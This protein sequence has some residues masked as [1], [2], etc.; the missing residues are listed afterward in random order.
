MR[1]YL[2]MRRIAPTLLALAAPSLLGACN[3]GVQPTAAS[4]PSPAVIVPVAPE[5]IAKGIP[6][7]SQIIEV[8]V[9]DDGDAAL[10]FDNL[11]GVRLWPALDGTRPPIPLTIEAPRHVSLAH[12]G[13][14]LLAVITSDAGSVRVM[15]LGHD[16]R[17]RQNVSLPAQ[18]LQAIAIDGGVVV[19]TADHAIE[20]YAADG[21]LRGRIVADPGKQIVTVVTRNGHSAALIAN[22]E[23][24]TS[25]E[26]RRVT[27]DDGISWGETIELASAVQGEQIALSPNG[28]RI[29]YGSLQHK[30]EVWEVDPFKRPITGSTT[31]VDENVRGI[32]F[33]DDS[34]VAIHTLST[35]MIQ[36]WTEFEKPT[37]KDTDPWAV[38]SQMSPSL[39]QPKDQNFLADGFA[40][41]DGKVVSGLG[42][43]L[44][45]STLD[46]V[47]YLGYKALAL[48]TV[49]AVDDQF[50]MTLGRNR[51]VWLDDKLVMHRDE[52]VSQSPTNSWMWAI[53][54]DGKH[55]VTQTSF[56]G[57]YDFSLVDL[58]T[59]AKIA[60]GRYAD[61]DRM[62]YERATRLFGIKEGRK[63]HRFTFDS[64][65]NTMSPLPDLRVKGQ[66]TSY[67][68]FDPAKANGMTA[69][70][71]GWDSDNASYETLTVYREGG[72][73]T[74]IYPFT[75]T[76][77]ASSIDGTLYVT[78]AGSVR[79]YRNGEKKPT[80]IKLPDSTISVVTPDG[81]RIAYTTRDEVIVADATGTPIWRQPQ[82][83]TNQL[84]FSTDGSHL[85]LHGVGGLA[86]YDAATGARTAR[87]CGWDFGLYDEALDGSAPG[88][89]PMCEDPMLQ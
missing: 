15:Q 54:L 41:A 73:S 23:L 19:R 9:T 72:K 86:T 30:L 31:P 69:A 89:A 24:G 45:V 71:V 77:G 58:D 56:E 4:K 66:T 2:C 8:A 74:R 17:V 5:P 3:S 57:R 61:V 88:A 59:K 25:R 79:V 46:K 51:F 11:L 36:L 12:E 84:M 27:I 13:R 67:M 70:V 75:G 16:G 6:H 49:T 76:L 65:T 63:L 33:L 78:E 53:P 7:G 48:G 50:A 26:V 55:I 42:V 52:D 47:Q 39:P 38:G 21:T 68:L 22:A 83:G 64:D 28:R 82:W 34:H 20:R 80:K 81:S 85:L 44:A 40:V 35:P 29:A 1:F 32:G 37:A 18:Y 87:E 62:Q 43:V 14:D 60:I 10:T